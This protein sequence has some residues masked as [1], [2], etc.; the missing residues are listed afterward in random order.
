MQNSLSVT[1]RSHVV[2]HDWSL[3]LC[4]QS[5]LNQ[6]ELDIVPA[7]CKLWYAELHF[8][9]TVLRQGGTHL[10]ACEL[11]LVSHTSPI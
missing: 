8:V 6:Q 1:R 11:Y 10:R 4:Y 7:H 5:D 9:H 2:L 3:N